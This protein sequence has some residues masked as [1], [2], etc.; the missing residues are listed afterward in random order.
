MIKNK[1]I[2]FVIVS[3]FIGLLLISSTNIVAETE[4]QENQTVSFSQNFSPPEIHQND[5]YIDITIKEASSQT[6]IQGK[7]ALPVFTK[8]FELPWGSKI[9]DVKYE[10]SEV[11]SQS[12][13]KKIEP[14]PI[15]KNVGMST[16]SMSKELNEVFYKGDNVFPE[17]WYNIQ[18]GA[19]I[20]SLGKHVLFVTFFVNPVRYIPIEDKIEYIAEF[21]ASIEYMQTETTDFEE[22]V[23]D[24]VIIAPE[25]FAENLTKLVDH[26]ESFGM[27]T[28]LT[29]LHDIYM[30]Y[31]GR[32]NPEKIKYF[33]KH[34]LDEWG[35]RY[36]LLAGDLKNLPIRQTDAYPWHEFHG[37]GILADLYYSDI[38]D[39]N[40]SFASWDSNNDSV[41]GE[42]EYN[43]SFSGR[44]AKAIDEVDLYPDLHIGRLA[45][46]NLKELDIVVDKII[47]YE[48]ETYEQ[49]WF[50][51]IILAGGDTFPPAKGSVP[52][53]YEGE[54]TNDKVAEQLPDFE[55]TRLWASKHTLSSLSF[56]YAINQ[57]AGFVSYAGHGFEH[58][59]GTYRPNAIRSKMGLN[60]PMYH[61]P[62]V[63]F[64]K[65]QD[66]LPIIFW[67]A[68]LTAKLDFNIMDLAAYNTLLDIF[69]KFTGLDP[70][71]TNYYT[72]F[73]WRFMIEEN[74]GAV[75]TIGAT[76]PAYSHVDRK[77]VHAGAGYLDWMFFKNYEEGI[78]FGDMFSQAQIDYMNNK[79]K[80]YFTIEEYIILGDPS[81]KLGGYP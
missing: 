29:I 69:I 3:F 34:A 2:K 78:C 10:I 38:Y 9:V 13:S 56:N 47:T 63:Q 43:Q 73:A 45:C 26:K 51:K 75:G 36:V 49:S 67:D 17:N 71:P 77:G 7:P 20:N 72:V 32:D 27:K 40:F 15:F 74:G 16:I 53:V 81:L 79:G 62:L 24:L 60:D 35:A 22:N 31:P 48:K 70:D 5:E 57:G 65:N 11:K 8:T 68:C 37:S 54:I 44:D 61:T 1:R 46:R 55:K 21:E 33:V 50:K 19:G 30:S 25:I 80:D 42:V 39:E 64:L 41:F 58:G 18:K 66:K 28:N 59:W 52:F 4:I 14:V 6:I 23:Y 12:V 76:R